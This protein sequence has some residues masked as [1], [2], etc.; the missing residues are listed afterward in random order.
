MNDTDII[1][2]LKTENAKLKED[3]DKL[4]NVVAQMKV[5]LNRLITQ[6]VSDGKEKLGQLYKGEGS[7]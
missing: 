4:L 1:S 2:E 7:C 6:Y 3:N 5:T